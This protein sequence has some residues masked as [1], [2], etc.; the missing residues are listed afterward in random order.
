MKPKTI[1]CLLVLLQNCSALKV[2]TFNMGIF[3]KS[4]ARGLFVKGE[5]K[6]LQTDV[7]KRSS[8]SRSLSHLYVLSAPSLRVEEDMPKS[9][10]YVKRFKELGPG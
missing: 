4:K 7:L 8:L 1:L 2:G 3:K 9:D 10:L 6:C 5:P